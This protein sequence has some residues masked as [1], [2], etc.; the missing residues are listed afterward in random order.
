MCI[1]AFNFKEGTIC[2]ACEQGCYSSLV[3]ISQGFVTL[4]IVYR[5]L[6]VRICLL[7]VLFLFFHEVAFK[8]SFQKVQNCVKGYKR[9]LP[10]MLK[11][12]LCSRKIWVIFKP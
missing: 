9:T 7:N 4:F 6:A 2:S 11:P 8:C 5:F 1:F 10:L 12:F 3:N